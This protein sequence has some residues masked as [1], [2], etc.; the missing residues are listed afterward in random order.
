LH[1]RSDD[2]PA[3]IARRLDLFDEQAAPLLLWLA[4]QGLLVRVDG[5]GDPD[6]VHDRFYAAVAQ[7]I[8]AVR[9]L[10]L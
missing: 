10:T 1:R 6:D 8:P 3:A 4:G 7:R 5:E 9:T 2:H